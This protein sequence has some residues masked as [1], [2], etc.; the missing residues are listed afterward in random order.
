MPGD[1]KAAS[2]KDL[3]T[4]PKAGGSKRAAASQPNPTASSSSSV[5]SEED[6]RKT[7]KKVRKTT[8]AAHR[9]K[10]LWAHYELD[11]SIPKEQHNKNTKVCD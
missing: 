2:Q 9:N 3:Y 5:D 10:A 6:L 1:K 11:P 8:V 7:P 4:N